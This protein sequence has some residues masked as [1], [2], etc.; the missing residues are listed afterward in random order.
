MTLRVRIP[1]RSAATLVLA[2]LAA[3]AAAHADVVL[4]WNAIAVRTMSAQNPFAQARL[5]AITQLAVFEAVNAVDGGFEPYLGTVQA[6]PDASAG[7]AA[8]AAAHGVLVKYFPGSAAALDAD[9]ATWLAAIPDGPPKTA[10]IAAGEAAAAAMIAAREG[11]GSAPPQF[12]LPGSALAGEWQLT[13]ACMPAGGAFYHWGHVAPFGIPSAEAFILGPPPDLTSNQYAKDYADVKRLG[14]MNSTERPQDRADVA[15]FYA[16]ISPSALSSEALRQLA[17]GRG[18]SLAENA[19]ALA[20]VA[21]SISDSLV[22]S[23]ATKYH[24]NFWRPETAIRAGDSDGNRKTEPDPGFVPFIATPCFPSYPSNHASGTN[25]GLEVLRRLYGA[26]GHSLTLT[27]PVLGVTRH[28]TSLEQISDNVDDAR[29]YGGIHFWFD[30]EGGNRLG[31]T[32]A[33]YVY[34]NNLRAIGGAR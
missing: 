13:P 20:L 28:Y 33:T 9:R 12:Y 26:A 21:M 2:M 3:P 17:A 15:R 7:A 27:N 8:I 4:D 23:F 5:L 24:Y 1:G 34:K 11:D 31:R 10:G 29:V 25:G 6:A 14:G 16:S 30:Q 19:R 32:I 22:V 18:N